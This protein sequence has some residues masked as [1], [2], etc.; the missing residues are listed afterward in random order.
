VRKRRAALTCAA[1]TCGAIG[2]ALAT[3]GPA[4]TG[5]TTQQCD[6]SSYDYVGGH[7]LDE[8]TYVTNDLDSDWLPFPGNSTI[9]IWFPL[10]LL[11]RIPLVPVVEVG[12]DQT[13]NS[14]ASLEAGDNYTQ[15]VGQLAI[16]NALSTTPPPNSDGGP[17]SFTFN[18]VD[19]GGTLWV[20]ATTCAK[21]FA[22][23]QVQFVPLDA[24]PSTQGPD[25]AAAPLST[26]DAGAGAD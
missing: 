21:Y 3:A 12:I 10:Q 7:M 6:Q 14:L 11:G 25:E 17:G 9:R 1:F 22:H 19:Y 15:G 23:I 8:N 13:P 16:F 20:T 18:K 5:C 4:S 26:A 2:L 24:G